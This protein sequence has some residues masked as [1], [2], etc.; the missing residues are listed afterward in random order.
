MD[1][2]GASGCFDT[3]SLAQS[4]EGST[5]V[6]LELFVLV[7]VLLMLDEIGTQFIKPREDVTELVRPRIIA[8]ISPTTKV[9]EPS[10]H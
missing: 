8:L 9:R 5:C 2:I 10:I 1:S 4:L 3:H 6:L 7:D